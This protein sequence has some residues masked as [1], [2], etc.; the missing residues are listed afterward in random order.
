VKVVSIPSLARWADEIAGLDAAGP[1]P[2]RIALVPS[3]AHA[4]ALRVEL[5]ARAPRALVGTQFFT[6]AAAA[7]A[8]LDSAGVAYRIGEEARRPLRLRKRFRAGIA[9]VAYRA[10]D[11]HTPGW[12]EAFASTIEQL[13]AAALRPE[14][15]ERLG[16]PR[17]SDLATIWRAVEDDAGTSWTVPRL[18]VEAHAVLMAHPECWRFDA[19]VL[20]AVSIGIDAACAQLI[21]VIPRLTL[22]VVSGRPTRQHDLDRMRSL[23]GDEAAGRL[24]SVVEVGDSR[25][26]LGILAEHL[27]EPPE[28]LASPER[29]RSDGPDGTV[30]LELYAGVDEELEAAARWV[31]DEVFHHGTPLRDLAILV[32]SP[33]PLATLIADRVEALPWPVGTRPV[34]LACGRP[35]V[36]ASAGARLLAVVRALGAYLPADA[37]TALLP[38]LRLADHEDHLSPGRARALVNKLGTIGGSAA[39]PD[40]ASRWSE[41]LTRIGVDEAARAVAPAVAGLVAIAVEM[42]AG[43]SLGRLWRSIRAFV[44]AHLI[45]PRELTAIIEQLDGEVGALADDAVTTQ[46]VGAEAVELIA[47]TLG[48][49]RLDIGRYGEPAIYVGTITSAAGLPFAAVRVIG[50]AESA[51]PGTLRADALLPTE[52]RSRLAPYVMVSDRDFASFRLHAFEQVARGVKHRLCVSAPRTDVDGSEREPAALFVEMAAALARPNATT[53]ERARAIPTVVE[54]ERDAFRAA[55]A[56]MASRQVETPLTPGAW[57]DRVAGGAR[58]LPSAWSRVVVSAP[59]EVIERATTMTGVLGP[60]R[61]TV[62]TPGVAADHPV[63]ASA[64]RVLLT[65][66]QRFLLERLLGFWCRAG[67]VETHRI[68]PA[69]YGKLVHSVA[70]RFSRAHG[71]AFGARECNLTHWLDLADRLAEAELDAFLTAYPLIGDGVVQRER[72]RLS[73][74]IRTF[75]EDDWHGGQPR[76]FVAAERAFGGDPAVLIATRGGPLFIAGRIDR[77]DVEGGTTLVRDLKTGRARSRERDHVDP[78]VNLDLQLAVYATVAERLAAQWSIPADVAAAYVYVDHLAATRERS[79]GADRRVLQTARTRW[80]ELAM[81]LLREQSYVRSPDARDCRI[82]PF[83]AVCGDDTLEAAELLRAATGTL[84]AFRELKA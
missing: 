8:V 74:D 24:R 13:E 35:A 37:M 10:E 59:L 49:M 70:E 66:P 4:H 83:A 7:R 79:F 26:E 11:L 73:R 34:Y 27:F 6:A 16:D 46:V 44:A 54:L 82:C 43:A 42:I 9:L 52:L 80:L 3:E 65:C 23:L 19:S 41:Q 68:D 20:A 76:R 40:D 62:R 67:G 72:R 81:A 84:A 69:S 60:A 36:A 38:R 47:A 32:P 45:A 77:I 51:Y 48:A 56:A 18:M 5:V 15:L 14:D 78:E 64:L 63:S 53:G 28:R 12:E 61:L 21:R 58:Q 25:G 50:V 30:S 57:L 29:R 31:A 22:G 17:A 55:R 33:E 2:R 75:I 1:L 39:R 71:L